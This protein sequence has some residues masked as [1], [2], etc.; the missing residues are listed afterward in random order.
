MKQYT[1]CILLLTLVFPHTGCSQPPGLTGKIEQ[2]VRPFVETNN[3]SGVILVSRNNKVLFNKAYGLANR[4]FKVPNHTE[5]VFQLASVSKP[6]TAA[7]ILILEQK[8]LLTTDDPVSKY[9][10]DYPSGDKI[11]LHHL[12]SHTSGIPDINDLEEYDNASRKQQTPAS[13]VA[14]YKNKPLVFAPGERYQYSNSNYSLL[15]FII[16]K[17]S[18][19]SFSEFL[20]ENIFGPL[21]MHKTI[22][23]IDMSLIIANMAEGY[24][25]DGNFGLKKAR[26]LDWS[27]KNGSGS[28]ASTAGDLHKWSEALFGT[29]I[30]SEKSKTKMFTEYKE[31]GYGWYLDEVHGQKYE[32]MNG[33]T[34]GICT[35]MGRYPAEKVSVIVL[36]NLSV[37]VSKQ[38]AI[39]LGGMLFDKA[40]EMPAL[41]RTLT[42]EELK[43][44]AG[45]YQFGKDFYKSNLT[46]EVTAKDGRLL[47]TMG[48]L[49]P[50]NGLDFFERT[51][52]GKVSF[53]K[54]GNGEVVQMMFDDHIGEKVN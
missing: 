5:T 27:S 25:P 53:K 39:N 41:N 30:L 32:F 48:E 47:C 4:E 17:I 8:G 13:L 19:I 51:Y 35:H 23:H 14:L 2:Y 10:P 9:V 49:F 54:D 3:F 43:A 12:L 40:V 7:A 37:F 11:K 36:S 24:A 33:M 44:F 31:S 34:S 26:Y 42:A 50:R 46:M 16:E 18:G 45:K 21:G 1:L 20:R 6:F 38:I 29:A 15:V 28:I 52:W 22:N